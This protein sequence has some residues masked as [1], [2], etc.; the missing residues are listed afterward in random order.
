MFLKSFIIIKNLLN[1]YVGLEPPH[2]VDHDK[3]TMYI[4]LIASQI[5]SLILIFWHVRNF[6]YL[7][8]V[9]SFTQTGFSKTKFYTKKND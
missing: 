9:I 1:T 3:I 8:F 5:E 7:I 6:P 4:G 2:F